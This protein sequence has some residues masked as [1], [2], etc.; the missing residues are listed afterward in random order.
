MTIAIKNWFLEKNNIYY[1]R[2]RDLNVIKETLKAVLVECKA[3]KDQIWIPKSCIVDEWE[4][5]TSPLAYHT[6]LVDTYRDA[7]KLQLIP[8]Y[9]ISNGYNSY[10]GDAFI[11]QE[12]N[13]SLAKL[14]DK[15]NV[16]YMSY[17]DWRNR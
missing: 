7:Y 4:K 9:T 14:L 5:E 8:N 2:G 3:T 15:Y 1:L 13:K 11:H 12:S 6:Y 17:N 16:E 10:S